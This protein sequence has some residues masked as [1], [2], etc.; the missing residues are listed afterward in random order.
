LLEERINDAKQ[1]T[2]FRVNL[3]VSYDLR[4]ADPAVF[5]Q[6]LE[7]AIQSAV[8]NGLLSPASDE[9]AEPVEVDSWTSEI[10]LS[11]GEPPAITP[12]GT[13]SGADFVLNAPF[14]T[15]W[16]TVDGASVHIKRED[17]GV[18]VDL[19]PKG[20]EDESLATMAVLHDDIEAAFCE[21]ME[22]DYLGDAFESW[23][24]AN[25][26][27]PIDGLRHAER[28][29]TFRRFVKERPAAPAG[30]APRG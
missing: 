12:E 25:G 15:A 27:E 24:L 19:Y 1:L 22:V 23:R 10:T 28:Y 30:E 7:R 16:I 2:H 13:E 20:A 8:G 14:E 9:V 21:S 4:G 26:I 6:A 17:E 5:A 18:V 29:E 11:S 3:D